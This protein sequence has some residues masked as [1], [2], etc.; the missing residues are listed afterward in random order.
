MNRFRERRS[1]PLFK[2]PLMATFA[3]VGMGESLLDEGLRF[4]VLS[5]RI[6]QAMA[7]SAARNVKRALS[8]ASHAS[9]ESPDETSSRP[10][11]TLAP[12]TA[13][14]DNRNEKRAAS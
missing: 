7:A 4:D 11:R 8:A 1:F 3:L 14:I 5:Q 9:A 6:S 2:D 10:S 12:V 13:G